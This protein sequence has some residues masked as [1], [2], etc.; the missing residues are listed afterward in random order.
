MST[1]QLPSTITLSRDFREREE[2]RAYT[3][4]YPFVQTRYF[5]RYPEL[6]TLVG[7]YEIVKPLPS[8][9]SDML[10]TSKEKPEL[11]FLLMSLSNHEF[12]SGEIDTRRHK[13]WR[14]MLTEDMRKQF[15]Q[16]PKLGP[17]LGMVATAYEDS[18]NSR[19][20]KVSTA[21]LVITT[22]PEDIFYM[23]NGDGWHSCQHFRD[24]SANEYLR[25]SLFDRTR[26]MAYILSDGKT[27]IS[28]QKGK[29]DGE[30]SIIARTLIHVGSVPNRPGV[31]IGI[32][33][34]YGNDTSLMN[35][36]RF[37]LITEIEKRGY[38]PVSLRRDTIDR[39]A[40]LTTGCYFYS[41][42][43]LLKPDWTQPYHDSLSGYNYQ[44]VKNG[45]DIL[46]IQTWSSSN[47]M[48]K[49]WSG[50]NEVVNGK[51]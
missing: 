32:D 47:A 49:P 37:T 22:S 45:E 8:W 13:I 23:S 6:E 51:V 28:E 10:T 3:H 1:Y 38:V 11:M 30:G 39:Q 41:Y 43:T 12:H 7:N 46:R 27:S 29:K 16:S 5:V 24:G 4:D 25:G 17:Y 50:F 2:V 9:W 21:K 26:A 19:G 15:P 20:T 14:A 48:I 18:F 35:A 42:P 33:R 40:G 31:A 34:S 36:M 44:D